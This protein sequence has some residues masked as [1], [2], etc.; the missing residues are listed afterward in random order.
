[1]EEIDINSPETLK[2]KM[3]SMIAAIYG[4]GHSINEWLLEKG[5]NTIT[6]YTSKRFFKMF[7]PVL[8]SLATDSRIKLKAILGPR[9]DVERS[10]N[11]SVFGL[12]S[13]KAFKKATLDK[14][15][16]VLVLSVAKRSRADTLFVER[17]CEV[18]YAASFIPQVYKEHSAI[19]LEIR[20]LL[21]NNPTVRSVQFKF[22]AFSETEEIGSLK[23]KDTIRAIRN[24]KI[25]SFYL[26]YNYKKSDIIDIFETPD[27]Y[28]DENGAIVIKDT[29]SRYVNA[30]G[31]IALL[32]GN[33]KHM[34]GQFG[35][36]E[37]VKFLV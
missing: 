5:Y 35:F 15:D 37:A 23:R 13:M 36:G 34:I 25:P 4:T 2:D 30:G 19:A 8:I 33:R 12:L 18:L 24:G 31:G 11:K 20:E 16:V 6:A 1:M 28:I 27:S 26:K 10:F 7:E 17:G 3:T 22:P 14:N 9:D 21:R 29:E 32:W